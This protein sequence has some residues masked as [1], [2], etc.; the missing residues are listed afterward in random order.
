MRAL[1]AQRRMGFHVQTVI[2]ADIIPSSSMHPAPRPG[3]VHR[4][5]ARSKETDPQGTPDP[6]RMQFKIHRQLL[7]RLPPG[8]THLHVHGVHGQEV[9]PLFGGNLMA[10]ALAD[11]C[12]HLHLLP[13]PALSIRSGRSGAPFQQTFADRSQSP[14]CTA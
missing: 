4:R 2:V 1:L 8:T 14:S 5:Q 11:H 6:P 9:R 7:R 12:D 10:V 3:G 13:L